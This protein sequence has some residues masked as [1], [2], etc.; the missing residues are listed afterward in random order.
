MLVFDL[1][2]RRRKS[3]NSKVTNW[4]EEPVGIIRPDIGVSGCGKSV[5][6]TCGE[7]ETE[8][9]LDPPVTACVS[10]YFPVL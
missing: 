9:I 2:G 1:D 4:I 6:G 8:C 10:P 5:L 7:V 3:E